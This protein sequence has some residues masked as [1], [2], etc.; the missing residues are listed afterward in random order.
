MYI[1]SFVLRYA[2]PRLVPAA[3]RERESSPAREDAEGSLAM[4]TLGLLAPQSREPGP[5]PP[6]HVPIQEQED[7]KNARAQKAG[8]A[9]V[10]SWHA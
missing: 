2:E 8:R 6:G 10:P 3:E 1:Y 5:G 4:L 7:W 9:Y